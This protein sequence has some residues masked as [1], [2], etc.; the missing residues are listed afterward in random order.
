MPCFYYLDTYLYIKDEFV[1][2]TVY[3]Y[4]EN[5][6]IL[7]LGVLKFPESL[8]SFLDKN[9]ELLKKTFKNI[10]RKVFDERERDLLLQNIKTEDLIPLI[11]LNTLDI[12]MED[13]DAR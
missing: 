4:L 9:K 12:K 5:G 10:N 8:E 7:I 2:K 13:K 11:D 1:V 6:Y 3:T